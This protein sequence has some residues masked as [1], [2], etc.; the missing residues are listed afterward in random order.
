MA[1]VRKN[2]PV[3]LIGVRL[4]ILDHGST[5]DLHTRKAAP[6]AEIAARK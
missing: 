2:D 1:K 5:F 6:A 3:C 4:H